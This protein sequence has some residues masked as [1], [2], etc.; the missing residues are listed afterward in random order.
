MGSRGSKIG[1]KS[2]RLPPELR[3]IHADSVGLKL[4]SVS[5]TARPP[6][7]HDSVK[8]ETLSFEVLHNYRVYTAPHV[9]GYFRRGRVL[10]LCP[11]VSA[12]KRGPKKRPTQ[13]LADLPSTRERFRRGSSTARR[14]SCRPKRFR[15][16]GLGDQY[17]PHDLAALRGYRSRGRF[18][19][20][21]S[22]ILGGASGQCVRAR[23]A[24]EES[25]HN[26][27][28]GHVCRHIE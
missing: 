19:Q 25:R 5:R 13:R 16:T 8:L 6:A 28:H 26:R 3:K 7:S 21:L 17:E 4:Q 23:S 27:R 14:N 2:H 10:R 18:L 1:D 11:E 22:R 24:A 9:V 12:W 15:T 20:S